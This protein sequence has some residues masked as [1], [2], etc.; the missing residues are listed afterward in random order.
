MS[1]VVPETDT[2]ASTKSRGRLRFGLESESA[3]LNLAAVAEW[4]RRRPGT[5]R[6]SLMALPGMTATVADSILDWL[7][8]DSRPRESGAEGDYYLGQDPPYA[9]RNGV[10]HAIE[11]LLLVKGVTR[12]LLF[13]RDTNRNGRIDPDELRRTQLNRDPSATGTM[14]GT[15]TADSLPWCK[16]LTLSSAERNETYDGKPRLD[17]N[18]SNLAQLSQR[19]TGLVPPDL[20][21]FIILYRQNGPALQPAGATMV[22]LA[23]VNLDLTRARLFASRRCSILSERRS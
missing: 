16:L 5:G 8:S 17:I 21:K 11:E 12:T 9:P 13:G 23:Q 2:E 19:L 6:K 22:T 20:A 7:D 1:A 10:P 14:T 3:R 4:E 15:T 18:G